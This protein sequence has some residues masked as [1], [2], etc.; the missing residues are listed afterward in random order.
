MK[1]V[2]SVT[3]AL[4]LCVLSLLSV[5]V[6]SN[7]AVSYID[8]IT[9]GQTWSD[10]WSSYEESST[11]I[12]DVRETGFYQITYNDYYQNGYVFIL[13]YDTYFLCI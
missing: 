12:L 7:A 5:D 8:S 11:V 2:L 3:L 13:I 4:V 9:V 6:K 1:K 10:S